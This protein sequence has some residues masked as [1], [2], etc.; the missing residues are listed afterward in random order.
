MIIKVCG[1]RVAQ[2]IREV[3][4]LDV[5]WIGLVFWKDSPR[6]VTQYSS[7]GGFI[8]DYTSIDSEVPTLGGKPIFR[9]Q[10]NKPKRVGVFVDDMPQNIVTRVANFKLDFV[11]LHGEESPVM[12]QN[13][14]ATLEPD[15]RKGVKIIKTIN[16]ERPEDFDKCKPYLGE[17][18]YFL[19]HNQCA[20]KGGSG[21]K[22]DWALLDSYNYDVPFLISGG[23][24]PDDVEAVKTISHPQF[25]GVDINSKF[26]S[27]VAVKDVE[28]VKSFVE[29]LRA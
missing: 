25:A 4:A 12:I 18:D 11:Q 21:E 29:A 2:N 15:I 17:V 27:E 1:L 10:E 13:L 24:G 14:R 6:Y 23:I 20:Q 7:R 5:D 3:S 19:F 28:K 16:V 9:Y 26:E 8:P 22:F